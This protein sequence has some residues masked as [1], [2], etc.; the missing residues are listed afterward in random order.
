MSLASP[1]LAGGFFTTRVIWEAQI[2][3][4]HTTKNDNWDAIQVPA[5]A[6]VMVVLQ[7]ASVSKQHK[8]IQLYF[9]CISIEI[10]LYLNTQLRLLRNSIMSQYFNY[11]S[12]KLEEI[13]KNT[14]DK[15]IIKGDE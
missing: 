1:A 6:M 7:Y 2:L 9:N 11:I 3:N 15:S 12:I 5:N 10:Q 14:S 13:N 8:L 4:T